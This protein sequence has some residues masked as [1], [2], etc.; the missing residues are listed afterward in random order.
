MFNVRLISKFRCA[1][2]PNGTVVMIFDSGAQVCVMGSEDAHLH[3]NREPPPHG[4]KLYGAGQAPLTCIETG[5]MTLTLGAFEVIPNV[6]LRRLVQ[7]VRV[8]LYR[9][10]WHGVSIVGQH[11]DADSYG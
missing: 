5:T 8:A 2:D 1:L 11:G 10:A 7:H 9:I 4:L 3:T 6:V